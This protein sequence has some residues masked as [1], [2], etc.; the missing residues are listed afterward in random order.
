MNQ[1]TIT[2][3]ILILCLTGSVH[4]EPPQ[5][6]AKATILDEVV[7]TAAKIEE[8][9]KNHPQG[10]HI[11]ERREITQ[12]NLSSVE[13]ILKTMP[14]V[15]VNS[16]PGLG[17]RISIRGSGRAGGVLVLLNGR[18]L[19]SNQYGSQDLNAIPADAIQSIA[20]FKPPV[21]VWLGPG[22]SDGAINI[23]TRS[24]EATK[25]KETSKTTAK[26]GGGSYGFAE[27]SLSHQLS[28]ADGDALLSA[29][30][31]HRDGK[32]QNS[33]RTDGAMTV[34]WNRKTAEGGGYGVS[35]R[36][37]RA[38]FGSPGPLDNLT[39]DARQDYQKLSADTKYHQPFGQTGTLAAT[40][41]G[42]AIS[43]E[44]RS[45]SGAT[46]D[47]DDRKAGLKLDTT[48]SEDEGTRDLR[49][50]VACEWDEF[51]HTLAGEHHRLRTAFSSQY[52]RRFGE[53]TP[54]L[55]L[56]GD[57]SDDFDFNPGLNAGIGWGPTEKWLFKLRGGYTVNIPTFEQLY[58]TTHGSIDQSRG[59]PDLDEERIWS[60]ELGVEYSFAKDRL[61]QLTVFRADTSDLITSQR[62][63]DQIYRPV[64]L[65]R[66]VR[67]GVEVTGK[68]VWACG[69]AS[70]TSFTLQDSENTE[71]GKDLPYT[72]A[73][74]IKETV[75]Y[76]FSGSKTR[77]ESTIRYEGSRYSQMENL[78]AQKLDDYTVVG[79]KLI[80]PFT[81]AGMAAEGYL[82]V[83]NL[84][85]AA[86][87]SHFGY[88]ADGLV[89][90]AGVQMKF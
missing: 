66:A 72:P 81:L 57:H 88:P 61:A 35:G 10:V 38:E 64:N 55:G 76:V 16:T 5:E 67:Q 1:K 3:A 2:L 23:V 86:Y 33:D 51:T 25:G 31:T 75:S 20:V 71:T 52:D 82:R 56:R 34:N 84:L 54:S 45:Q 90:V 36:Y 53:F 18:P 21:P 11:V 60:Y 77:F 37:Y 13:E 46:A 68:Y 79:I 70:E 12:R 80:Q 22:G 8:Y 65:D 41:Y 28:I 27:S 19:N 15:E 30:A 87:Q 24:G 85:D 47:L 49:L 17:S 4:A 39:P 50:G 48:W 69:F 43:V 73:V 62:G 42:D 40:L 59:N 26:V 7:V 78:P 63:A 44:D 89:A 9:L 74:K 14:G 83:E 58:Q 32:R 29:T 6:A